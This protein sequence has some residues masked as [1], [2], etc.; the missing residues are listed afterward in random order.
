MSC[1]R[2]SHVIH[3]AS[4]AHNGSAPRCP[5]RW[6]R[7]SGIGVALS[8]AAAS[9]MGTTWISAH[10]CPWLTALGCIHCTELHVRSLV[11]SKSRSAGRPNSPA[12]S[13]RLCAKSA[14]AHSMRARVEPPQPPAW[15][16]ARKCCARN[17][18]LSLRVA[19]G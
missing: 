11:G 16:T 5:P 6:R 14:A 3:N 10:S 19:D 1:F 12:R 9:L 2:S 15:T 13:S 17:A 8:R 7:R 18:R 4:N